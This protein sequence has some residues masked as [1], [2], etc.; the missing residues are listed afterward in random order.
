MMKILLT[1]NLLYFLCITY[2]SY[3]AVK[4]GDRNRK[5]YRFRTSWLEFTT[6]FCLPS[7]NI[8]FGGHRHL[9]VEIQIYWVFGKL[10]IHLPRGNKYEWDFAHNYGFTFTDI[11][12]DGWQ[13]IHW[14]WGRKTWVWDM[15]WV[16][17]HHSTSYMMQNGK[18]ET[19]MKGARI[20]DRWEE[21][22]KDRLM[23]HSFPYTY[24]LKS[25]EKQHRIARVQYVVRRFRRKWLPFTASFGQV[26]NTLDIE[27]N[28]EIGEAAGRSWKGGV[29]G[30]SFRVL[31]KEGIE[32]ALRR[33]EQT[34][35]FNR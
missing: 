12:S 9:Q 23:Q 26:N 17:Q 1:L 19:E 35:R 25:G 10:F 11:N 14:H 24:I 6:G 2:L 7:F 33:M 22:F 4:G 34:K 8:A 28:E 20:P 29:T 16:L 5:D 15:P 13:Q 21:S 32:Q 31:P 30:C 3:C 27:F 18:W